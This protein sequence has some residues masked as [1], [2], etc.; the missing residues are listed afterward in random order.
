MI[1][2]RSF[3]KGVLLAPVLKRATSTFGDSRTSRKAAIRA[4]MSTYVDSGMLPFAVGMIVQRNRVVFAEAVGFADLETKLPLRPDAIF[5]VRSISKPVTATGAMLLLESG[6]FSLDDPIEKYLP[7]FRGVQIADSGQLSVPPRQPTIL[8]L[9][10]H[11]SGIPVERPKAIENL[12]RTMDR[13]LTEVVRLIAT[14]PLDFAPGE[15]WRYSSS[16]FAT[17]GRI[18]EVVSNQSFQTFMDQKLFAPLGMQDSSFF[19]GPERAGR[20]P[21]MY[22]LENRVLKRDSL[23]VSR[24]AQVYAAP[25]FGLCTTAK[26]LVKLSEMFLNEGM[27]GGKRF[28]SAESV[29]SMLTP[30]VHTDD[31]ALEMG[32][33]WFIHTAKNAPAAYP[34]TAGSFGA[35]GASGGLIWVDPEKELIRIFLTHCF[36]TEGKAPESFMRL[37]SSL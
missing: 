1:L 36:G 8:N 27:V 20:I 31:P 25:E 13:S 21:T 6:K 28:L 19:P 23:D 17:L 12:T 2:R 5:D 32:L 35:A 37:A 15:K 22:T 10:T 14:Q 16:G 24:K 29:R 11:T 3:L 7:E 30:S 26:D 34:E 9:L 18:I 4:D 33:G